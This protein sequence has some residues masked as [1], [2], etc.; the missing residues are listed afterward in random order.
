M[1]QLQGMRCANCKLS[2]TV[3]GG[4]DRGFRFWTETMYCRLCESL[5]DV[6]V[7]Y[8][9]DPSH[10]ESFPMADEP[11]E[12]GKCPAC[13]GQDLALWSSGQPCP[14]C[15]GEM[16]VSGIVTLAD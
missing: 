2:A 7:A 12:F 13:G 14:R 3:S 10:P 9:L 16:R 4:R 15:G 5:T 1:A 6:T 8:A 11:R